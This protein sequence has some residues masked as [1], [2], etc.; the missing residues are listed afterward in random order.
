MA[1]ELKPL[2]GDVETQFTY[3][4]DQ[5]SF[6]TAM[7]AVRADQE[8]LVGYRLIVQKERSL[9]LADA[10]GRYMEVFVTFGPYPVTEPNPAPVQ[11][12]HK[13]WSDEDG[14]RRASGIDGTQL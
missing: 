2:G 9:E 10:Q 7:D 3:R 14:S 8:A 1:E 13:P 11:V 4:P 6:G 12:D 5:T